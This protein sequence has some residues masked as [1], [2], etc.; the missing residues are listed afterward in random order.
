MNGLTEG[1]AADVEGGRWCHSLLFGQSR[2]SWCLS[3]L[4][5]TVSLIILSPTSALLS[6]VVAIK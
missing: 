2:C 6:S 5:C 4:T 1:W 3:R